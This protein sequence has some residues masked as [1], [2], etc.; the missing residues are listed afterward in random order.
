LTQNE[1]KIVVNADTIELLKPPFIALD[2]TEKY[3]QLSQ[4][5]TFTFSGSFFTA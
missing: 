3:I 2:N 5:K 4:R 1:G